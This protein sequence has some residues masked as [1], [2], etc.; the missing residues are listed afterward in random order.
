MNTTAAP[1]DVKDGPPEDQYEGVESLPTTVP[2]EEL[3]KAAERWT[4][5]FAAAEKE[6]GPVLERGRKVLEAY[7]DKRTDNNQGSFKVNLFWSNTQV[8]KSNIYAK[9]PKV[10]VVR[11]YNDHKDDVARVAAE[12]LKR[13]LNSGL[14]KVC[15]DFDAAAFNG[16]EDY[17]IPGMG[18]MWLDY[19]PYFEPYEI[20]AQI[21]P[22]TGV[23]IAPAQKAERIAD[24]D[25]PSEHIN[26]EDFRYSPARTWEEVRWTA[27]R[28]FMSRAEAAK[29]FG[30]DIV[31]LLPTTKAEGKVKTKNGTLAPQDAPW[32]RIAVWEIW[33]KID[34]KVYWYVAGFDQCLDCRDDPLQ[35]EHFFP[36]PKPLV[37]NTTTS[38]FIPRP[39]YMFAQDQYTQI[40]ELTTRITYLTRACKMVGA[41]D[42]NTTALGRIFQEGMENQMIPVDNWA[43]FAEKGGVKGTM[44]FV[45]IEVAAAVIE[46]LTGQ[47]EILIQK[48]YE[49][50][51]IADIMRGNSNPNETLGAQRIK[52]QFGS[53]RL[54]YK[55]SEIDKW[56]TEAQQIK[57]QIICTHWQPETIIRRSNIMMSPDAEHAQ[58]AVE[59]LKTGGLEGYRI[60]IE[61]E[62]M[63]AIDWAREQEERSAAIQGLGVFMQS[64]AGLIEAEK[65]ALPFILEIMKWYLG[66]FSKG[67]DIEGVMDKAIQAAQQPK[68][69]EPPTPEQ[70]AAALKDKS[71][72][73]S[74]RASAVKS[75]SD[76][77]KNGVVE[78]VNAALQQ[79]GLPPANPGAVAAVLE[80]EN[81]P[82]PPPADRPPTV[83]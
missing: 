65:S 80:L 10:D 76:A 50:M 21:D 59:F 20:P 82:P 47:R 66:G 17:L 43:A 35:L 78:P 6:F 29:R 52:A 81:P 33:S 31:K 37:A 27:K 36:C 61:P 12:I 42:K 18:Q 4:K 56:A 22:M 7:L 63:A 38:N 62:S 1:Q 55:Q 41:Y 34:R 44:D 45:P 3:Q 9:P 46:K 28:V 2:V 16:I 77:M 23:E 24:E 73:E 13:I 70:Q 30:A 40:D 19:K 60:K 8:I 75:L 26:W 11:L 25:A 64:V 54:Q 69:P 79:M 57:A 5:E 72:A 67:R 74:D 68:Q 48:L 39:D 51:G 49:V 58:Q 15:S 14:E 83:Q 53:A 32:A 71:A